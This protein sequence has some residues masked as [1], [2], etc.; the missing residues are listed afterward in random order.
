M[1]I[2][3][4]RPDL[5]GE[6]AS[7]AERG[8]ERT[9]G[10]AGPAVLSS[11]S[12]TGACALCH[13]AGPVPLRGARVR[14]PGRRHPL[15]SR[16]RHRL[17]SPSFLRRPWSRGGRVRIL[18]A[19]GI[20]TSGVACPYGTFEPSG[21][22][23]VRDRCAFS[24]GRFARGRRR[25]VLSG[26]RRRVGGPPGDRVRSPKGPPN[27]RLS[28]HFR[29][30]VGIGMKEV[31]SARVRTSPRRCAKRASVGRSSTT[32]GHPALRLTPGGSR[33]GTRRS[34]PAASRRRD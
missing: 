18:A 15:G 23:C 27:L 34:S 5:S 2:G 9:A 28:K 25:G 12:L 3:R 1:D 21:G 22:S 7:V 6:S 30:L 31:P 32:G 14:G 13:R 11:L 10:S 19:T 26:G 4:S 29:S 8:Q 20:G 16:S 17:R 24:P 33:R